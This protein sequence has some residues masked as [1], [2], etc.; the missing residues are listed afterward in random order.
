MIP[1]ELQDG[2]KERVL[3]IFEGDL[4]KNPKGESVPLQVFEQHLPQKKSKDDD[5]VPY[6]MVQLNYGEQKTPADQHK[7][8]VLFVVGVFYDSPDNQGHKEVMGIINKLFED[9]SRQ[10]VQDD[11]FEIDFPIRWGLHEED[12]APYYYG[13]VETTWKL[14]TI[15]REDLEDYS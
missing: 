14:P 9:F 10:P 15:R 12:V 6:V 8:P 13:A 3:K 11:R 4:F 2:L 5:P 1:T 7:A